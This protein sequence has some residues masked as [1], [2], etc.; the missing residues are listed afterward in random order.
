MFY[1][2]VGR[3]LSDCTTTVPT[4][5][6]SLTLFP[7]LWFSCYFFCSTL[8]CQATYEDFPVCVHWFRQIVAAIVGIALGFVGVTGA[9]GVIG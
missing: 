4:I 1:S 2:S 8:F 9:T 3:T 5:L 7:P 6:L